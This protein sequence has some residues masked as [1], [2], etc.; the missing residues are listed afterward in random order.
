MRK[1]DDV[2][3]VLGMLCVIAL[4]LCVSACRQSEPEAPVSDSAAP[5]Q[6]RTYAV[7]LW[8]ADEPIPGETVWMDGDRLMRNVEAGVPLTIVGVEVE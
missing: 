4:P 8:P 2:L 6:P 1:R 3:P 5:Y 7:R